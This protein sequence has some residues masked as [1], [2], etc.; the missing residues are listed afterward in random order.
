[1]RPGRLHRTPFVRIAYRVSAE[2]QDDLMDNRRM[3]SKRMQTVIAIKDRNRLLFSALYNH[4]ALARCA[5]LRLVV[6]RGSVM[7]WNKDAA[8]VLSN[9]FFIR[10]QNNG[11]AI[12]DR[13][14]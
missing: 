12:F 3:Q 4:V 13:E 6:F 8:A 14:K 10:D 2:P 9:G 1:M 11:P 7:G 5:T